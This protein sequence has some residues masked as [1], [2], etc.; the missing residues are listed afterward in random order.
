MTEG[1][2]CEVSLMLRR[3]VEIF[4]TWDARQ[5]AESALRASPSER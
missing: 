5:I 3:I 4:E 2:Q 1:G